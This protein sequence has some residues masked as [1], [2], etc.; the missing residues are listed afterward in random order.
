MWSIIISAL[1][2]LLYSQ[3]GTSNN[4]R[5]MS[6]L[7]LHTQCL[8]CLIQVLYT[9]QRVFHMLLVNFLCE[10][11]ALFGNSI[12]NAQS[13][14]P[15]IILFPTWRLSLDQEN[16]NIKTHGRWMPTQVFGVSGW[17][18]LC[19]DLECHST[20]RSSFQLFLKYICLFYCY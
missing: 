14:F 3:L 16:F 4:N 12:R 6:F 5:R 1:T 7:G 2:R 18:D 17:S 11:Q 20:F 15:Q 13:L 10:H 9:F 8:I 19:L